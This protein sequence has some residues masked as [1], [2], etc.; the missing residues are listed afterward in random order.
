MAQAVTEDD[1]QFTLKCHGQFGACTGENLV[2]ISEA[3]IPEELTVPSARA[4]LTA[5]L[6]ALKNRP[7]PSNVGDLANTPL[8]MT[9]TAEQQEYKIELR[10]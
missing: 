2:T 1:G 9:V 4:Q 7:I 5:Y 6:R 10:R 8:K 3:D